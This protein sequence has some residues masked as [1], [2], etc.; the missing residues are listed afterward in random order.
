MPQIL[1]TLAPSRKSGKHFEM[2]FRMSFSKTF[3]RQFINFEVVQAKMFKRIRNS[4]LGVSEPDPSKSTQV[5]LVLSQRLKISCSSV[6]K[7]TK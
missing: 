2:I 6:W 4:L 1:C 7:Q 3:R 5:P